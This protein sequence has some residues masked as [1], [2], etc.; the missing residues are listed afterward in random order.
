MRNAEILQ[1]QKD[2]KQEFTIRK[3]DYDLRKKEN[4]MRIK[5]QEDEQKYREKE[6]ARK[7]K[8][9][10]KPQLHESS[11][12][13]YVFDQATN[14]YKGSVVPGA[15]AVNR[16]YTRG[17]V[18]TGSAGKSSKEKILALPG[19]KKSVGPNGEPIWIGGPKNEY[20]TEQ[21]YQQR[22]AVENAWEDDW[23]Q[24]R[25]R[26]RRNSITGAQE[27][28]NEIPGQP[29]VQSTPEQMSYDKTYQ[30]AKNKEFSSKD[31]DM[32]TFDARFKAAYGERP[33]TAMQWQ[34]AYKSGT[35]DVPG[36]TVQGQ[37]VSAPQQAPPPPN[38]ATKVIDGKTYVFVGDGWEPL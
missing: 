5:M 1:Q 34:G 14:T 16:D 23:D 12:M 35:P 7:E 27:Y 32:E 24:R 29:S 33:S 25:G 8:D 37:A 4:D 22:L 28:Y 11:G 2:R 17:P 30:A 19:Y 36:T 10:L 6:D 9:A 26:Y 3:Q 38:G 20:L 13:Q 18:G 15:E 21:D 31:G